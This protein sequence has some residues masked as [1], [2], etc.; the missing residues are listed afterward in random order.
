MKSALLLCIISYIVSYG[1]NIESNWRKRRQQ[2]E[3]FT[4][5]AENWWWSF[6]CLGEKRKLSILFV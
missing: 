5:C 2:K 6:S 4:D 1:K 3:S